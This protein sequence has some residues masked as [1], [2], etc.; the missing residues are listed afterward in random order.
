VRRATWIATF[1][2]LAS[3]TASS[4]SAD[5][6]SR[7]VWIAQA[8]SDD[9]IGETIA[10]PPQRSFECPD[11]EKI[12]FKQKQLDNLSLDA[13]IHEKRLP[14]DCSTSV[15]Q[16]TALG[17]DGRSWLA[18]DFNWA[19][20]D[21][22]AQPAYFDDPVLERYGQTHHPLV[23]PWLSGAHFFSQ[24]PLMSYKIVTDRPYDTVYTLG[25]HRPGSPMPCT[26][27]RWLK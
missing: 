22:Y 26:A 7:W 14:A 21:L 3:L 17:D 24:F 13:R 8:P 12:G 16:G 1:A 10:T 11:L 20:S 2:A 4:L 5:D 19:A 18:T 25:Y 9:R 6:L 27:L 23:Q 15:F